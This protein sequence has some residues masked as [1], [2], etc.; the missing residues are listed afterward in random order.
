MSASQSKILTLQWN[1]LILDAIK[2]S[3]TSPP[4]AARALAMVYTAMYDAW[5]VYNEC[6]IS[7]GT[8]LYIKIKDETHCTKDNQHTAFSYAAYRVLTELFWL[9]LP[10]NN[11]NMFRSFMCE[12][13]YDPD[14]TSVGCE[15]PQGI[16][17]LAA[18]IVIEYRSG[19]GSNPHA[20]LHAPAWS[21]YTCYEPVNTWD[22][23]NDVNYWQPLRIETESGKY[24]VQHSLVPHWALVKP[25][26]LLYNWQFRPGPPY[27][28]HLAQFKEQAK[29]I[30]TISAGLTDKQKAIAE[31]WADGAGTF[32]IAGHWCEIAQFVAESKRY[33]NSDCIK[34]FFAVC[35]AMLDASIACW[36][37]KRA[38]DSGR[39]VTII[40]E[41]YKG[42]DV[43]AWGGP[44][45]GMQTI[46]GEN[47]QSYIPTPPFAEH[48]SVHSAVSYAAAFIL[49]IFTGSDVFGGCSVIER[50]CSA[51]EKGTVPKHDIT[52]EWATF[53]DAAAQAGLAGLYGGIHFAKANTDGQKLGD[54]TG[55]NVWDKV[56]FFFNE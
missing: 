7:T 53:S 50:N 40:R 45:K 33:G 26:S 38:Y 9:G 35:N 19:D 56:L 54:Q 4:L 49:K 55:K 46:K 21:D 1:Q 34:L 14:D 36:E 28:K 27:K 8:A 42:R 20:T 31:Y 29:E 39:P 5:S 13:G 10:P 16:G 23:L 52:L 32:S 17:N 11:K 22:K 25:F 44:H 30:L 15:T 37:C 43:A 18:A 3:C 2:Y 41:L 51:T 47:W 6:A 24:K 48:V 12:L